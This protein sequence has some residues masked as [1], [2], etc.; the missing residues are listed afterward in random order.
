MLVIFGNPKVGTRLLHCSRRAA[1]DLPMK[2]LVWQDAQGRVWLS[3]R[4]PAHLAT[5]H[6]AVGCD[7]VVRKM[8]AALRK[9]SG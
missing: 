3:D 6:G 9:P 5:R 1:P 4:D 8:Q 7:A 2:A